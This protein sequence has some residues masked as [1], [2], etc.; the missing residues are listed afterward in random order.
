MLSIMVRPHSLLKHTKHRPPV[1]ESHTFTRPILCVIAVF[2]LATVHLK[3]VLSML[4]PYAEAIH[5]YCGGNLTV[6]GAKAT[7]GIFATYPA[8][9]L[10]LLAG[11]IDQVAMKPDYTKAASFNC[12]THS[13]LDVCLCGMFVLRAPGVW[14]SYAAALPN[15]S[16]RP[17]EQTSRGGQ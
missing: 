14:H 8:P 9:Y 6:T 1:I 12:F 11:F 7:A 2:L 5:D 16:V 13:C 15:G 4:F 3:T 17:E 10:S